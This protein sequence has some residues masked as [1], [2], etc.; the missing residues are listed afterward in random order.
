MA[1]PAEVQDGATRFAPAGRRR[2]VAL[3]AEV[4]QAAASPVVDALLRSLGTAVLVVNERRQIVAANTTALE[5]MG[6]AEPGPVLGLRPGEAVSCVHAAEEPGGCGCATACTSCGAVLAVLQALKRGAPAERDC[7]LTVKAGQG[8]VDLDLRV[9]AV[10]LPVEGRPLVLVALTDIAAQQRRAALER[11][12]FHDLGNV[13]TALVAAAEATDSPDARQVAEAAADV[14]LITDRLVREVQLQRALSRTSFED[15]T[16][17]PARLGAAA[18]LE[19]LA[20]FFRRQPCAA[21]RRLEVTPPA[22]AQVAA[23]PFLLAR[24]LTNMLKNAFEA[25]PAG[26]TVRL[27]ACDAGGGAVRFEVHNPGAIPAAV[28]P[29]IFQRHFSTKGGQGR[30]EGTWSMK[31]LGERLM[32]GRVAFT[33]GREEGTTFTLT[34]PAAP[35]ALAPVA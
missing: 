22:V 5:L 28:A 6:L 18:L 19:D 21:G 23:D 7:A 30:G 35:P 11:A 20:R 25:T 16:P 33:S 32:G 4:S 10:P 13:L 29:R 27:S 24:V 3:D 2:G 34:L 12:F 31:A 9:R 14:R 17:A 15:Y 1:W 26:G 8:T